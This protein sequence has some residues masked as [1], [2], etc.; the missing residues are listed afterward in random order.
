M[1]IMSVVIVRFVG[2]GIDKMTEH[3]K[4]LRNEIV[5]IVLPYIQA[6]L[7]DTNYDT[8]D[9]LAFLDNII[10]RYF[11]EEYFDERAITR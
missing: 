10:D 9:L 1:I 8:D 5:E 7:R 6:R 4:R 3:K 2:C 11:N